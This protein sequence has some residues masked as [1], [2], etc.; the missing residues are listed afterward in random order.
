[1]KLL[2][3]LLVTALLG[4]L[5]TACATAAQQNVTVAPATGIERPASVERAY[6]P[7]DAS[8]VAST[9]RPQFLDSYADW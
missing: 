6:S 9:G 8:L 7:S 4:M 5:A 2:I 1:M 3:R